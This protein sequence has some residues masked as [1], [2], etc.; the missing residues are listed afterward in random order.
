LRCKPK[1]EETN[2][3]GKEDGLSQTPHGRRRVAPREAEGTSSEHKELD[4]EA[5]TALFG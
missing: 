5:C 4:T 2:E 1:K 3:N